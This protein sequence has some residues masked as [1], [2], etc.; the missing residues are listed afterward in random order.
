MFTNFVCLGKTY[1]YSEN[2]DSLA[3]LGTDLQVRKRSQWVCL[4]LLHFYYWMCVRSTAQN[5]LISDKMQLAGTTN[6]DD[7]WPRFV[8]VWGKL[9]KHFARIY[10]WQMVDFWRWQFYIRD[11]S[12]VTTTFFSLNLGKTSVFIV[13]FTIKD[14]EILI[15]FNARECSVF[16]FLLRNNF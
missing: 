5:N 10:G 6:M 2:Q 14:F 1:I 9:Y 12:T 15:V 7:M 16:N 3:A 4:L 8:D 13:N 11:M